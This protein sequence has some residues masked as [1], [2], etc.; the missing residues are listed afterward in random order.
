MKMML[1]MLVV[2]NNFALRGGVENKEEK[3]KEKALRDLRNK[4]QKVSLN[5]N[6]PTPA[7]EI[8][9][10]LEQGDPLNT[11]LVPEYGL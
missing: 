4:N 1:K 8:A 7:S 6:G 3:T 9:D 11:E 5:V 10:H 2:S